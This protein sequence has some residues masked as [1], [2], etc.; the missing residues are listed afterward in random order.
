MTND[1]SI[2]ASRHDFSRVDAL[3]A[4]HLGKTFPAAAL[5]ILVAGAPVY[6]RAFGH[7]DPETT[8]E[9]ATFE[10]KF[11]LASVSKLFTVTAFMTLVEQGAVGLDHPVATVLPEFSGPR[12]IAPYP[13]PLHPGAVIHVV[14]PGAEPAD[15]GQ[16][17][18][19]HLLAHNS[20]LPAWLALWKLDRREDR[21]DAALGAPF[22]YPTGS[23]VLY[24]D[25]GLILL[26]F[27]V[28][29][30]TAR[31]LDQVVHE[32][33][34]RPLGLTSIGY[35]PIPPE[36]AAPTEYY[37]HQNRRMRGEVHDENAWSFGGV[38]GHAG[39]FGNVHDVGM[40]GEMLRRGGPPVRRGGP[41]VLRGETVA[42]MT[43]LQSEEGAVR[44]G[45]GLLLW[46]PDPGAASHPLSEHAFGHMG[47]TGTSLWV[48]PARELVV[49]CL[50]NRVYYG[51][52]NADA[53]GAFRVALHRVICESL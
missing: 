46:S 50:T 26:G 41:P 18:F 30:L 32:R 22:S 47:F 19:R 11:D 29:R 39:L 49:A 28:E 17:T 13:D 27:A 52:E 51:R 23:H 2:L 34:A 25:I 53:I 24:S 38:A 15:A 31:P 48:D 4:E 21:R 16:V 9:P 6:R 45:L 35:G 37:A 33:V 43:R 5:E 20:G 1:T 40:L 8:L 44:R 3:V 14:P 12:P 7:L 10:T 36:Q 42:E